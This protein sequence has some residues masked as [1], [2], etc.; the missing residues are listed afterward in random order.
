MTLVLPPLSHINSVI[1]LVTYNELD[2]K[3]SKTRK[4]ALFPTTLNY[5]VVTT[6][7]IMESMINF[8]I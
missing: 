6:T 3:I 2:M 7:Q 1:N 4:K 8:I 5:S